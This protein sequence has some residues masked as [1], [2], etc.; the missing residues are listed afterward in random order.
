M[1]E[2]IIFGGYGFIGTRLFELTK[3]SIRFSSSGNQKSNYN[4]SFFIAKIKKYNQECIFFLSC[5]PHPSFSNNNHLLDLKKNN[6][7]IQNLL[8]AAK[9]T[10]FK[11]KII[12]AS[13]IAVYGT[14]KNKNVKENEK[15]NPES[16]YALSKI[17]AEQQCQFYI[18]QHNLN[19]VI[20]RFC[21]VFGPKLKRQII[22]NI[23]KELMNKSKLSI[24]LKGKKTDKRE[25]IYIDDLI[26]ILI[27]ITKIKIEAGIYNIGTGKQIKITKIHEYLKKKLKSKTEIIFENKLISP[28]FSILNTEKIK[29]K[30]KMSLTFNF[31]KN[32]SNTYNYWKKNRASID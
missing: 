24:T 10:K 6:I 14:N 26:K 16:Q 30:I 18:K 5:N 32:L 7:K 20:L 2:N 31:F 15:L 23:I 4:K 12:Y 22:F 1:V 29:K 3:N 17:M 11:G 13:S 9:Q 19:V 8:E 27:K 25:F 21:S 28:N